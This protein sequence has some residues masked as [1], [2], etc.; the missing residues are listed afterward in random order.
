MKNIFKAGKINN[1][2]VVKGVL[3]K[4]IKVKNKKEAD[5]LAKVLNDEWKKEPIYSQIARRINGNSV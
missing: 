1:S 5:E 4:S 3:G 2:H